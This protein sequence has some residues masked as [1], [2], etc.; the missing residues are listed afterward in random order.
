MVD[1]ILKKF[2]FWEKNWYIRVFRVADYE[3]AVRFGKLK[4]AN[5]I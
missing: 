2:H 4:M 5:P 3:S 1:K